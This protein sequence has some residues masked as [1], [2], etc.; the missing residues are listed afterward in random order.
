M[1]LG[2][3]SSKTWFS[4]LLSL[5]VISFAITHFCPVFAFCDDQIWQ[6]QIAPFIFSFNCSKVSVAIF[7]VRPLGDPSFLSWNRN[8][9]GHFN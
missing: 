2:I 3:L 8:P 1:A 9:A 4:K 5:M 6:M 7:F